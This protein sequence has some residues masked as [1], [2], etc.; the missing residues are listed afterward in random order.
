MAWQHFSSESFVAADRAAAWEVGKNGITLNCV[1][2]RLVNTPLARNPGR[3]REL[4]RN[5]GKEAPENPTEEQAIAASASGAVMGIPWMQPD[6]VA[7]AVVFLCT[8]AA[9]RISGAC[10]DATAGE[11]AKWST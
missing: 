8:N 3:W 5:A 2:P 11:S 9:N 1:E 4:I 7:P 10:V 6:E